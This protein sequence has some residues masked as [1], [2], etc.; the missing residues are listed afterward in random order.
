MD[1]Y[2]HTIVKNNCNNT[3]IDNENWSRWWGIASRSLNDAH[4]K[5]RSYTQIWH[6]HST[7]NATLW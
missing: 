2:I 4:F 5:K 6:F 3:N 7:Q 1:I